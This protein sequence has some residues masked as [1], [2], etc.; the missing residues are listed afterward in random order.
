MGKDNRVVIVGLGYINSQV[1]DRNFI[2]GMN[3]MPEF[4]VYAEKFSNDEKVLGY[5][6]IEKIDLKSYLPGRSIRCIDKASIY[7][8]IATKMAI[9]DCL[10]SNNID[11]DVGIVLGIAMSAFH[12]T[13]EFILQSLKEGPSFVNPM[14]FPNTVSNAPASRVG[15]WFNLKGPSIAISNGFT[16]SMDSIGFAFDEISF[17]KNKYYLAGGAEEISENIY[18]GYAAVAF[19]KFTDKAVTEIIGEGS[20]ILMLTTVDEAIDKNYKIYGEIIDFYSQKISSNS[21]CDDVLKNIFSSVISKNG[22]DENAV[23]FCSNRLPFNKFSNRC[24]ILGNYQED[25][26][27]MRCIDDNTNVNY[28]GMNGVFNVQNIILKKDTLNSKFKYALVYD[29]GCDCKFSGILIKL[30][31]D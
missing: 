8:G 19:E 29:I 18:K 25:Q 27:N 5:S 6:K 30:E 21:N 28:L 17:G 7:A 1:K 12:S 24:D 11:S 2:S 20:G 31:R 22:I 10:G 13:I 23:I 14:E 9:E 16:A 4:K 26:V 15:I 3:I